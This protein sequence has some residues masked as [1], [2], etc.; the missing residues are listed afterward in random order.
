MYMQ[1]LK[2]VDTC[3]VDATIESAGNWL[4]FIK[5]ANN[6]KQNTI[7]FQY[8]DQIYYSTIKTVYPGNELFVRFEYEEE[9][10]REM[11]NKCKYCGKAF[12][13]K[14]EL[15]RPIRGHT[16]ERPFI[17]KT[18]RKS[19]KQTTHLKRHIVSA[20]GQETLSQCH[21]CQKSFINEEDLKEQEESYYYGG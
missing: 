4:R 5:L 20:H 18:C 17:C 16:D 2:G 10:P 14:S 13:C 21:H 12:P 6:E 9:R 3:F 19:F 8:Y 11:A 15:V 7:A 1:I